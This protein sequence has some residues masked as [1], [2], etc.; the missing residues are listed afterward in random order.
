MI[1]GIMQIAGP[2]VVVGFSALP[3]FGAA[4]I[5]DSWEV[6]SSLYLLLVLT[7]ADVKAAFDS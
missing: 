1:S 7:R 6:N 4:G 2:V 5:E 3:L